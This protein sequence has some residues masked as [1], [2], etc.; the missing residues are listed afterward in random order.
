M[1]VTVDTREQ[2]PYRYPPE[3][4]TVTS[5][6]LKTGDYALTGDNWT[7]ER[8]SV[9]DLIGTIISD[10]LEG[11][12]QRM[13]EH[14]GPN[15][16]KVLCVDGDKDEFASWRWSRCGRAS[17]A[18]AFSELYR[19]AYA[20][21]RPRLERAGGSVDVSPRLPAGELAQ[22]MRAYLD[23]IDAE[24]LKLLPDTALEKLA[25]YFTEIL[26]EGEMPERWKLATVTPVLKEGK[27][28]QLAVSYRPVAITSLLCRTFERIVAARIL[29]SELGQNIPLEQF[30]FRKRTSTLDALMLFTTHIQ[31][32]FGYNQMYSDKT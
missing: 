12:M 5:T 27:D 31:D 25:H 21:G 32:M 10:R 16:L 9:A 14:V 30:G 26:R 18:W 8:K 20:Y 11:Q 2:D 7:I 4:A 3:Y 6:C 28:P 15:E 23:G 22:W 24:L 29:Q 17:C 19:I 13:R 1:H